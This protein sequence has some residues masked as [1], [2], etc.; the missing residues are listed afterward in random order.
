MI[1]FKDDVGEEFSPSRL[2]LGS[3]LH[4]VPCMRPMHARHLPHHLEHVLLHALL[5]HTCALHALQLQVLHDTTP[6]QQLLAWH[7]ITTVSLCHNNRLAN[8]RGGCFV[9][10]QA[11]PLTAH[12]PY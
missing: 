1:Q 5:W 11:P 4:G 2:V 7:V 9:C 8:A 3:R 12:V 10:V 6:A